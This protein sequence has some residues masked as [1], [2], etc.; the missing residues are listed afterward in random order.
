ME[1]TSATPH[2]LFQ[3]PIILAL[4]LQKS[5]LCF[6]SSILSSSDL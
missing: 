3:P 2:E 1:Y 5:A 4:S 6:E